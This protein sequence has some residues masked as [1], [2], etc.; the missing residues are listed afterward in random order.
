M[1]DSL[2]RPC[3]FAKQQGSLLQSCF[4]QR[5]LSSEYDRFLGSRCERSKKLNKFELAKIS[6]FVQT[7]RIS[8]AVLKQAPQLARELKRYKIS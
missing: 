6:N 1:L 7:K 2:Q 5:V 8:L 3:T 4:V